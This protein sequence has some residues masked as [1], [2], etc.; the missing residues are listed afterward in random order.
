MEHHITLP[1]TKEKAAGL[2]CGDTVYLSGELYT[3]RDA[4]HKR[5]CELLEQGKPLPFPVHDACL[6][7]VGPS[8]ARPGQVIGS[9]GPT[10]SYRMDSYAPALLRLGLRGMIGKGAR[11]PEVIR[12]MQE[13]GA[14]YLAAIGGAGALLSSCIKTCTVIAFEDLGAEAIHHL[15]VENFPAVVAI[16]A[17]GKNLYTEGRQNYLSQTFG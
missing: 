16:D 2:S 6:Y 1:L 5:L 9:A 13:A 8:P 4:A 10:T 11:S 12:A 7:Y 17:Q 15:V 14:V 3:G